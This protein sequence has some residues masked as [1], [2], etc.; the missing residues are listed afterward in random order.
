MTATMLNQGPF[1]VLLDGRRQTFAD[2]RSFQAYIRAIETE[3]G[4][5]N[6][7]L[8]RARCRLGWAL[9][10]YKKSVG[11]GNIKDVYREM[12][13]N[14]RRGQEVCRFARLCGDPHTGAMIDERYFDY[15][16]LAKQDAEARKRSLRLDADGNPSVTAVMNAA[17]A[18][19]DSRYAG[20]QTAPTHTTPP[21]TNGGEDTKN[22]VYR[23]FRTVPKRGPG[24]VL[25]AC[26]AH[27]PSSAAPATEAAHRALAAGCV[28]ADQPELPW[29]LAESARRLAH[30]A[31][32]LEARLAGGDA[33]RG[34]ALSVQ[35]RIDDLLN[36][37]E[38]DH[39]GVPA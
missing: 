13:I 23:V 24:A 2:R 20:P 38:G 26:L 10:E 16:R 19:R 21:Q 39:R 29:H 25:D 28:G 3:I 8:A 15:A 33:D 37:L 22:A 12:R 11:H 34:F 31:A 17:G 6:I 7:D 9:L 30:A 32:G 18:T 1:S 27:A 4:D 14:E 35:Q 5:R 36:E